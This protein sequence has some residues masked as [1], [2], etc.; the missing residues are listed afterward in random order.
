MGEARLSHETKFSDLDSAARFPRKAAPRFTQPYSQ[1]TWNLSSVRES[2]AMR[3]GEK[4][5]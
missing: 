1:K 5:G 2:L 3:D 4:S